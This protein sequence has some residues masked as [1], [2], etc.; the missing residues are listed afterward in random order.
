MG[1]ELKQSQTNLYDLDFHLWVEETIKRLQ[2]KDFENI[3]LEN[4]IEEIS[5]L[6]HRQ[7]KKL[8][9]LLIRLFEHLLKLKYW[10][11]ERINNTGHWEREILNFRQQIND[12]L[13]DSPSL[14]PY[15]SEIL[16][17]CF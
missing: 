7:K 8:K 3:D 13:Q 15:L 11:A 4:L 10:K 2:E 9:N 1:V 6:S 17:E 16:S 12:E 14:R 5:D